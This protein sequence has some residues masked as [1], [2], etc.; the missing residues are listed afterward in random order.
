MF[1]SPAKQLVPHVRPPRRR[2]SVPLGNIWLAI[3]VS[4]SVIAT[5][6]P[7][8]AKRYHAT[9]Q[10]ALIALRGPQFR[11]VCLSHLVLVCQQ[12]GFRPQSI[13]LTTAE[14]DVPG[15]TVAYSV[16]TCRVSGGTMPRGSAR[17]SVA[18]APTVAGDRRASNGSRL[19]HPSCAPPTIVATQVGPPQAAAP[20]LPHSADFLFGAPRAWLSVRGT[21]LFP[22]AGGDLFAFVTDEF[23]LNRSDLRAV[24]GSPADVGMVLTPRFDFVVG[25]DISRHETDSEYRR[26]SR[27]TRSRS[28]SGRASTRRRFSGGVRFSPSGPRPPHQPLR[29]HS[30][31]V[32]CRT[33]APVSPPRSTASRSVD[34]SST[35]R[36]CRSST[37]GS[38]PTAGAS[39]PTCTAEWTFRC[40]SVSPSPFDGRSPWL[41]SGPRRR[42]QRLRRD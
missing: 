16:R 32:R 14:I 13:A 26:S 39:G 21:L 38:P 34:S 19:S 27:R 7:P 6:T 5:S 20:T 10:P 35:S 8:A 42:L 30:A 28:R 23:T 22:R 3:S 15:L 9:V 29:L 11:V 1:H 17:V 31:A 2:P 4:P 37:I 40:G 25:F 12:L 41:H 33:P 18:V 36:T 24:A